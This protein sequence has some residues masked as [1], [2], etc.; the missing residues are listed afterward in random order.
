MSY[1]LSFKPKALKEWK[2]LDETIRTQFK[3]KSIEIQI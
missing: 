2:K 3:K 1:E